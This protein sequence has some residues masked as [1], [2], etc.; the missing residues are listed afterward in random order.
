MPAYIDQSFEDFHN[1]V[2][3][4][5]LPAD[6]NA[7][8]ITDIFQQFGIIV[9]LYLKRRISR[10]SPISLPNPF[11]IL[12]FE[13]RESVDKVLAGRPYFMNDNQLFV[14]RCL[15]ITRRYPYEAYFNTNKILLRI[16]R[17]NHNEILPDDNIIADYLKA[18]G[19]NVLRLERFEDKTVLVEF[20]DYDPV[21]I[22]CLSRPHFINSQMIEIEKCRDEQQARRRA[23]FQ[24]KSR[25]ISLKPS[26]TIT[27][28]DVDI[29]SC[30]TI[31]PTPTLNT[32]EQVVQLRLTY[33]DMSNR[34]EDEHEQLVSSLKAEWEQI[35]KDRIRLQR[36]TLD[37]KQE[38][39]RLIEE[40]RRWKK[41]YS[42]CLQENL[43][44]QSKDKQKLLDA[45]EK[46]STIKK[47]YDQLIQDKQQ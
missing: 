2:H 35:A 5:N 27:T 37:Y 25:S 20:D 18:A 29:Q 17:E 31:S 30:N 13:K 9:K 15:P 4:S 45:T 10:D 47:Y 34:L 39:E 42:E 14:R 24:Q 19:G 11:V 23:Q 1:H 33:S 26:P 32:D 40:N 3:V 44:I 21:D 22:C 36:L 7:K 8:R 46:Y 38:Q 6:V 12:I 28:A 16:P 41:L 43:H